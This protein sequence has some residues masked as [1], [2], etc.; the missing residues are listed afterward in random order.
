M[1]SFLY[2][3]VI[4]AVIALSIQLPELMLNPGEVSQGHKKNANQCT[5]CHRLFWGISDKKCI[6]CHKPNEISRNASIKGQS[7]QFHSSLKAQSCTSCHTDHKG[8]DPEL[9]TIA[10][11]HTLLSVT[12]LN[13]CTSCHV[14]PGDSLHPKLSASCGTCHATT[15]WKFSGVFDHNLIRD[16][17]KEDCLSC[18]QK[19]SD[20][21]HFSLQSNCLD[22]HST[23][24]WKPASF[25][26]STYFILDRHHDAKCNTC[27]ANNIFRSY[28]CYG[29][30]EHSE[31]KIAEEHRE[32]GI[33]EFSDCASCHRSGNKHDIQ[34]NRQRIDKGLDGVKQYIQRERKRDG[35]KKDH[36]DD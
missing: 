23:Q 3:S 1:K 7:L 16:I 30:H 35:K 13:N 31:S 12:M 22:C 17:N 34:N 27:H 33:Y 29:C 9:A 14:V 15:E 10:F 4:I 24:Q 20:G 6:V 25:D 36:D 2:I 8:K 11:N 26:H 5:S 19:P 18:H 21:F 28:T 32:E